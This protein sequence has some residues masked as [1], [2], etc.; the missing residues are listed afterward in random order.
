MDESPRVSLYFPLPARLAVAPYHSRFS[1]A[2]KPKKLLCGFGCRFRD[3]FQW[4]F[5][6]CRDRFRYHARVS[7]FAALSAK[8]TGARYGQSVSTMNFQSGICAA[9]SRTA[10]PFLKVTIPVNE[11][12]WLRLRTSFACSSETPKQ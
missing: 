6:R 9:T 10:A 5:P 4:N 1:F 8:G 7:R 3:F 11:T 12:R 2:I